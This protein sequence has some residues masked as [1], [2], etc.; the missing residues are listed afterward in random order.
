VRFSSDGKLVVTAGTN[1]TARVWEARSGRTL[2]ILR[3]VSNFRD[4]GVLSASFSPDVRRILTVGNGGTKVFDT[5][6]GRS[7]PT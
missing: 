1:D 2:R 5:R 7:S 4:V 6:T 3:P